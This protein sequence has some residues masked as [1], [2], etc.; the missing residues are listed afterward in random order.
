MS[1]QL[2]ISNLL[3]ALEKLDP[4]LARSYET[5]ACQLADAMAAAVVRKLPEDVELGSSA[6]FMDG[7][8]CAPLRAVDD[9]QPIPA[10]LQGLDDDGWES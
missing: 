10:A 8:L 3:T 4:E 9:T 2:T 5:E 7:L 1:L 6:S